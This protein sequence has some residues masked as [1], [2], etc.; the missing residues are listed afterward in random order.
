M[1]SNLKLATLMFFY[2]ISAKKTL[3]FSQGMN[4]LAICAMLLTGCNDSKESE[5]IKNNWNHSIPDI[6]YVHGQK[7]NLCY[8]ISNAGSAAGL[9]TTVPCENLKS[10]KVVDFDEQK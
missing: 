3:S 10:V 1:R 9:F 8:A 5:A 4:W 7:T 2:P 6:Y